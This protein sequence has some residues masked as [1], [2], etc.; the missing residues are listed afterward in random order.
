MPRSS[1][2]PTRSSS[3]KTLIKYVR[4]SSVSTGAPSTERLGL[5]LPQAEEEVRVC[6]DP[7]GLYQ[8]VCR[9]LS[10]SVPQDTCYAIGHPPSEASANTLTN[11]SNAS[12][13][14][15]VSFAV[16]S[17][18]AANRSAASLTSR[19]GLV[20]PATSVSEP[21]GRPSTCAN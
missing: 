13:S 20:S 2:R 16:G 3:S 12:R 5:V 15:F 10:P 8:H 4:S 7:V 11:S 6:R 21:A 9:Y 17:E 18:R 19:R 14:S 1:Y